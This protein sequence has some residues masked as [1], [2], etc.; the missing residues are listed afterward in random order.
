MLGAFLQRAL[1]W[2]VATEAGGEQT[3]RGISKTE[4]IN[5]REEGVIEKKEGSFRV[6]N[7]FMNKKKEL[8][9]L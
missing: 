8:G 9:S 6:L 3:K 5:D 2:R 1:E 7:T 4:K